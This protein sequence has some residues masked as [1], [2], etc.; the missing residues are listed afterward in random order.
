MLGG[1]SVEASTKNIL[2]QSIEGQVHFSMPRGDKM[3]LVLNQL[4][5]IALHSHSNI[6]SKHAAQAERNYSIQVNQCKIIRDQ[7]PTESPIEL[8]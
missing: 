5:Y 2:F 3:S 1:S 6:A 7:I 8:G 4:K